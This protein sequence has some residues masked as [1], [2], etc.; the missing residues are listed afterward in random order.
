MNELSFEELKNLR[1]GTIGTP[2]RDKYELEAESIILAA[3]IKQLRIQKGMNQNELGVLKGVKKDHMTL[4]W[5][6][7]INDAG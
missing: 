4:L 6:S 3:K 1:I 5:E 7:K 2:A